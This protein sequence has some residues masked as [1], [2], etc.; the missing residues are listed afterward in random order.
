MDSS[1]YFQAGALRDSGG[2]LLADWESGSWTRFRNRYVHGVVQRNTFI[3][4]RY[5][6]VAAWVG[7]NI[8]GELL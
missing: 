7:L 2:V 8:M 1:P 3:V 4:D 5:P 6:C